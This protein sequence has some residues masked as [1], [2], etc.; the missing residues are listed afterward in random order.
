VVHARELSERA[1]LEG[2][3]A[4]HVFLKIQGSSGPNVFFTAASG[5]QSVMIGDNLRTRAGDRLSFAVQIVGARGAKA[6]IVR[7]GRPEPFLADTQVKSADQTFQFQVS[8]DGARHWYRV[9]LRAA[10]GA[11]LALTNPIYENFAER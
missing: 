4:G 5:T 8:S 7:D 1:L 10:N 9:I 6:E 3:K 11:L 2:I